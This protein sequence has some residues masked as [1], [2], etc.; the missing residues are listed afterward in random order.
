MTMANQFCKACCAE[1][2]IAISGC[3][4]LADLQVDGLVR[5]QCEFATGRQLVDWVGVLLGTTS[6]DLYAHM[7]IREDSHRHRMLELA[8][9]LAHEGIVV[10]IA[11]Q[12]LVCR[13]GSRRLQ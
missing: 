10:G 13:A 5:A 1:L 3:R 2:R 4:Y 7:W 9:K 6:P 8:G 11:K 12:G